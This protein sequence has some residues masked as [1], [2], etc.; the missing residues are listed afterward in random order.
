MTPLRKEI[1][2]FITAAE[3]LN[4]SKAADY[5]GVKQSSISKSVMRLEEELGTKL[6]IRGNRSLK[7]T[8]S[9]QLF[10]QTSLKLS[11]DWQKARTDVSLLESTTAGEV[12]IAC[13]PVLGKFLLPKIIP[14]LNKNVSLDVNLMS[15]RESVESVN[16]IRMDCCIAIDPLPYP[17]LVIKKLWSEKIGLYSVDGSDKDR[18]LYNSKMINQSKIL[19]KYPSHEKLSVDDYE[20][21]YSIIKRSSSH[22]ALLPSPVAEK[23]GKLKLIKSFGKLL[24]VCLVYRQ[25]TLKTNAFKHVLTKIKSEVYF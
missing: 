8:P 9:G 3:K 2:H 12:S 14:K 19:C 20:I 13:H 17:D 15:S 5:L 6:F 21:I 10:H 16:D 7:I 11:Q 25:D 4:F 24:P 1:E 23:E 22:M 18:I